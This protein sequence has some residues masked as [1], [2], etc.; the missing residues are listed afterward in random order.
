MILAKALQAIMEEA[1]DT[2]LSLERVEEQGVISKR[3]ADFKADIFLG[4]LA[5]LIFRGS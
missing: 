1:R 5:H 4:V 3:A 2:V